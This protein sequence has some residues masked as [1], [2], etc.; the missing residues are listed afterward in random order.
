MGVRGGPE[1]KN[2]PD[3][4]GKCEGP[5]EAALGHFRDSG[6]ARVTGIEFTG[7]HQRPAASGEVGV[8]FRV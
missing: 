3:R 8:L 1:S 6:E 4:W 5:K 2:I 7:G